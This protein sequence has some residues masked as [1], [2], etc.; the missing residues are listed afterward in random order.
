M[1]VLEVDAVD[2]SLTTNCLLHFPVAPVIQLVN[3]SLPGRSV[4]TR[5]TLRAVAFSPERDSPKNCG[6]AYLPRLLHI[7]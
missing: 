3:I 5:R 2:F 6:I 4:L 7:L 1:M